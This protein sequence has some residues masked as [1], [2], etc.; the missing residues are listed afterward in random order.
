M[1]T[2]A[3]SET[4]FSNAFE[5]YV[6]WKSLSEI[7]RHPPKDRKTGHRPSHREFAEGMGFEDEVVF[8]LIEIK[9]QKAFAEKYGITEQTLVRWNKKIAQRDGIENMR[10]WARRLTPNVVIM[11]YLQTM[12]DKVSPAIFRLWYELFGLTE[13]NNA[14]TQKRKTTVKIE[15]LDSIM[16]K[17]AP[18]LVILKNRPKAL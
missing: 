18:P 7:L 1:T 15:I 3:L 11:M 14:I 12:K 13:K 17:P 2:A 9:T 10:W 6:A 8:T 16:T 5:A 4:G